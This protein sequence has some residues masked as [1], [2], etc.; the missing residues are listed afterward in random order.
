VLAARATAVP[1]CWLGAIERL[2]LGG[3]LDDHG[4]G[5][6]SFAWRATRVWVFA[7][8]LSHSAARATIEQALAGGRGH[9]SGGVTALAAD[10]LGVQ[11]VPDDL[12]GVS[13]V[14]APEQPDVDPEDTQ[15]A[16]RIVSAACIVDEMVGDARRSLAT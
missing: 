1:A 4:G 15:Q 10:D 2:E 12:L 14:F 3:A 11:V 13:L 7:T 9:P 5:L 8:L 16:M 6:H